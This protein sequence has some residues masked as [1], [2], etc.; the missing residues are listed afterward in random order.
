[1]RRLFSLLVAAALVAVVLLPTAARADNWPTY[2]SV[3]SKYRSPNYSV[4]TPGYSFT[5]VAPNGAIHNYYA[6]G[7]PS[8]GNNQGPQYYVPA[9][10]S[11]YQ[12]PGSLH[13]YYGS[14]SPPYMFY[15]NRR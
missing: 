15:D 11:Y 7:H 6:P 8:N 5:Q 1:M 14:Y 9:F 2:G 3:Y 4:Y 10:R 12:A 13:N